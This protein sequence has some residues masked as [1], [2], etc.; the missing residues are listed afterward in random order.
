LIDGHLAEGKDTLDELEG[1]ELLKCY[2]FKTLPMAVAKDEVHAVTLAEEIGYPV[3]LKIVSP[4]I[5]HKSDASG[6]KVN[7]TDSEGVTAAFREIVKNARAYNEKAEIHGV[8]VQ[9][10][11]PK[12]EEVILGINRNPGK[13]GHSLMF[14]LGG[15]FVELFKDVSFRIAPVG[16]NNARRMIRSI[17]GYPML[18]GFRRR[19]LADIETIEKSLVA[20]S[21]LAVDFPI[22]KE[23]DINPLLVYK[24]GE[25]A[26]V[27]D[28]MI[29]LKE[30]QTPHVGV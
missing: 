4:Q 6:V 27:A 3:V 28:V 24:K 15:I 2:G 18:N 13:G 17:K 1:S 30:P 10:M 29:T 8:L 25:G 19:P 22:I 14:G 16:R 7:I 23:L 5:L 9:K 21:N 11:A 20:L 12:G 26:V